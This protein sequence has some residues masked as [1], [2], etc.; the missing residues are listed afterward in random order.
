MIKSTLKIIQKYQEEGTYIEL[1]L[2]S[3]MAYNERNLG[4][5]EI[6]LNLGMK[7]LEKLKK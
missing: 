3:R 7:L 1:E 4:N 5:Y 2:N 6:S